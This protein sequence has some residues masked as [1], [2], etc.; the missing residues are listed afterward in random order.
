MHNKNYLIGMACPKCGSEGSF[1]IKAMAYFVVTDD[2]TDCGRDVE[3]ED[4]DYC[5]CPRCE[6]S[7][8]TAEFKIK[9]K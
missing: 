8:R 3:W 2:G 4:D 6:R 9:E 5:Y 1:H 7:G